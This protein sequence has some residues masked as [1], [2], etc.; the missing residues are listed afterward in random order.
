MEDRMEKKRGIFSLPAKVIT[1]AVLMI[2]A[3]VFTF[4]IVIVLFMYS[5][6]VSV[7]KA[8]E[9]ITYEETRNFGMQVWTELSNVS[10]NAYIRQE[11]EID[12]KYDENAVL[13]ITDISAGVKKEASAPETSYYLRDLEQL[14]DEPQGTV[15]MLDSILE[16]AYYLTTEKNS[17][18]SGEIDAAETSEESAAEETETGQSSNDLLYSERFVYLYRNGKD[19]ETVLPVSGVSLADYAAE[20]PDTVSLQT[21][22]EQLRTALLEWHSYMYYYRENTALQSNLQYLVV[23]K[24]SKAVYSQGFGEDVTADDFDRIAAQDNVIYVCERTEG[25]ITDQTGISTD[26]QSYLSGFLQDTVLV[27]SNEKVV[28]AINEGY[29]YDDFLRQ[30]KETFEA[31]SPWFRSAVIL[32]IAGFILFVASFVLA[33]VQ[34]GKRYWDGEVSLQM[35]DCMPLE[36]ELCITAALAGLM[37]LLTVGT[38]DMMLDTSA[39]S[40]EKLMLLGAVAG[41]DAGVFM[42]QYLSYVRRIKGHYFWRGSL[43]A[44]LWGWLTRT[45]RYIVKSCRDIYDARNTS[46][47]LILSFGGAVFVN[48]LLIAAFGGFGMFLAVIVDAGILLWLLRDASGR[49][50]LKDGLK[51]ISEGDLDFKITLDGMHGDNLEMAECINGLGNGLHAA[52]Q[53]SMKSEKLKADLITNVSHDIKTPLTS[54]INYVDLLKREKIEDEKI[55]GYI[56]VLDSKSQ[57]LKQLTEDLVEAS[58]ISSGNIT[59]EFVNLNLKELIQQ[60]NGEFSERFEAKNLELVCTLPEEPLTIRADGRRVWRIIENLYVNIAKYAMPGTRVYVSAEKRNKRVIM[61]FKNISEHRLNINADELTERFIRGDIS[62]STEGSGLGL[63][64]AKNLAVLQKGT[65][66]IYLDGDLFKVTVTFPEADSN[67]EKAEE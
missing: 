12:G 60:T 11:F 59:L 13:D 4:G 36:L 3:A 31:L 25:Q 35:M 45:C 10:H 46:S 29:P 33:T 49:Q 5:F 2:S 66:D 30:S 26:V 21:L 14:W 27:S 67:E 6:D 43:C 23:D 65:F 20:N 52:V 63:S 19:L 32:A 47:K 37:I 16:N 54:I 17:S 44:K 39:A 1:I 22:Y 41:V 9:G 58:K 50:V 64:I 40:P 53:K 38:A 18:L 24:D 42:W 48:F 56:D 15:D 61:T 7:S 28:V 51:K 34:T 55:K 57:R 62:R 8:E